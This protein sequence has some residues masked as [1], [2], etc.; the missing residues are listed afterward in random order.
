MHVHLGASKR[1]LEA[2][3]YF[4]FFKNKT[5]NS[6]EIVTWFFYALLVGV[7]FCAPPLPPSI[8]KTPN[9]H[10]TQYSCLLKKWPWKALLTYYVADYTTNC[11]CR[12]SIQL[13]REL[14]RA[15]VSSIPPASLKL[16]HLMNC[17]IDLL[18]TLRPNTW[19]NS[20]EHH[21]LVHWKKN[22][23]MIRNHIWHFHANSTNLQW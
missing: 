15:L 17:T 11:C 3:V 12:D 2:H 19:G 21:T 16:V 22:P 1:F 9:M 18:T 5:A 23:P 4:W 20:S 6:F 13:S 10:P 7:L 8:Y 14:S